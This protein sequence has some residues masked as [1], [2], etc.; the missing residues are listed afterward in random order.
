[1]KVSAFAP[2]SGSTMG[3][4]PTPGPLWPAGPV[5]R[6]EPAE[7]VGP[8]ESAESAPGSAHP[9]PAGAAPRPNPAANAASKASWSRWL[10]FRGSSAPSASKSPGPAW[11][12]A[13]R[14]IN[15]ARCGVSRPVIRL[16]PSCSCAPTRTPRALFRSASVYG[17]SM[18]NSARSIGASWSRSS[19]STCSTSSAICGS[20]TRVSS[21]WI[22]SGK[23]RSTL[24]IFS[25]ASAPTTPSSTFRRRHGMYSALPFDPRPACPGDNLRNAARRRLAS[26]RLMRCD[27]ANAPGILESAM[28][29]PSRRARRY[30]ASTT[31]NFFRARSS[32]RYA[33]SR[34]PGDNRSQPPPATSAARE[35]SAMAS[36]RSVAH[37]AAVLMAPNLSRTL[38]VRQC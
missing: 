36:R 17:S 26:A 15:A 19:T 1:M 4:G 32:S 9:S 20:A 27:R 37:P 16:I 30:S 18:P 10:G 7:P 33:S 11:S 35:I 29:E 22:F 23:P 2:K 8:V 12:A 28:G 6:L 38:F 14:L 5:G 24:S 3:S 31:A 34:C 21:P 25:T 13:R